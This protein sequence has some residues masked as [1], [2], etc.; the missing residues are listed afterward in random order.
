[1]DLWIYQ[2]INFEI[3]IDLPWSKKFII[4]EI[5]ITPRIAGNPNTGPPAQAREAR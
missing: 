2:F 1:M 4:S 3:E 5:S